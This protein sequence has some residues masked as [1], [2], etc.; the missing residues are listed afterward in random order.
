MDKDFEI[1]G[2]E[3]W[4]EDYCR[5]C[6]LFIIYFY[7]WALFVFFG[8]TKMFCFFDD[9]SYVLERELSQIDE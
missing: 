1:S 9:N 5:P 4:C 6:F 2:R 8:Q 7:L 3:T